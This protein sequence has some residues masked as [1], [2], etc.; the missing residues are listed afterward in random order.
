MFAHFFDCVTIQNIF[1][2]VRSM[3][4]VIDYKKKKKIVSF[5]LACFPETS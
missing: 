2:L 1:Y 4:I 5:S 3:S